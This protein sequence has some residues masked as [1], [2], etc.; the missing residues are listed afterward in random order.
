MSDTE[1]GGSDLP[2]NPEPEDDAD[3]S[4]LGQADIGG[5]SAEAETSAGAFH[6][7]CSQNGVAGDIAGGSDAAQHGMENVQQVQE[8]PSLTDSVSNDSLQCGNI[9]PEDEFQMGSA[10]TERT[11]EQNGHPSCNTGSQGS[12]DIEESPPEDELFGVNT[13]PDHGENFQNGDT[14]PESEGVRESCEMETGASLSHLGS[15]ERMASVDRC[16]ASSAVE[17]EGSHTTDSVE[18]NCDNMGS[19]PTPQGHAVLQETFVGNLFSVGKTEDRED[20]QVPE[21]DREQTLLSASSCE[22]QNSA[23]SKEKHGASAVTLTNSSQQNVCFESAHAVTDR[24]SIAADIVGNAVQARLSP[25]GTEA[26]TATGDNLQRTV[27]DVDNNTFP[28]QIV[29]NTCDSQ[30]AS[31]QPSRPTETSSAQQ[32][33]NQ[34]TAASSTTSRTQKS[35]F[36]EMDS[37]DEDLL[38]KLDAELHLPSSPQQQQQH[39]VMASKFSQLQMPNGLKQMDG[40][41]SELC[42]QFEQQLLQ[43]QEQL[44]Q[45]EREVNRLQDEKARQR[46]VSQDVMAERDKCRAELTALKDKNCDDLY[47]PQIKELEYTIAQQQTEIRQL[48]D[49]LTSHDGAAKRAIATLQSEMKARMDQITKMYEETSREKDS[50]VVRF[51]EAETK[52]IEAKRSVE[53]MEAKVRDVL[54][55]KEF[56]N[57]KMRAAVADRQKAITDLDAKVGEMTAMQKEMEKLKEDLSSADYRI[58]WFQNKLKAELDAHKDTKQNLEK[59]IIKLKETK[60]ETEVIRRDCHAIIKTYQESEE[61]RSNSLDKELKMKQTELLV[62]MKQKSDTDEVHLATKKELD[63][64][65]VKHKDAIEELKTLKDKVHCF[66]EERMTSEQVQNKY[67]TI[68]QNQKGEN[69]NLQKQLSDL[70]TLKEDYDRA[71]DM[72]KNLDHEISDLKITNRD[73]T[74]DIEGCQA[75][76]S[77]MLA[78]QSELSRTNALLRS[79][80][81]NFNNQVVTLS[82]EVQKMSMDLQD[83]E[84]RC[85][86]VTEQ[87]KEEQK[88]REEKTSTLS[89]QLAARTK[90]CDEFKQKWE[91][92]IDSNKTLKRKHAHNV[93]DLT[94][95]LQHAKKRLEVYESGSGER[96]ATSMG[97]RTNSNGSLNSMEAGGQHNASQHSASQHN[98]QPHPAVQ[99]RRQSQEPQDYPVITEQVEV[100][101]QVLIER[102]VRL[103]RSLARKNEKLEFLEE[104]IQ[105]LVAEIK[106]KNKIIQGYIM[107]EEAGT[108][109]SN[110]MDE[111][112]A[113]LARKGGIMASVYSMHQQDGA[114]TLDLSLEINRKLQA[115]LEDTLLKNMTLKENLDTLGAEIARLSQENRRLQLHLQQIA[116]H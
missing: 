92:E 73:L 68:I 70:R 16:L 109:V 22:D 38:M 99:S 110:D 66:E 18:M 53:K 55:E 51:A 10:G 97:S 111:N 105:Q 44:L 1:A 90:E 89:S 33:G 54:K 69:V 107:R 62:H 5:E 113:L 39:L 24:D 35:T 14:A 98:H 103:Q 91:D 50:M 102:I 115:V 81:T 6:M 15:S 85:R 28:S 112:K 46:Q 21:C 23:S 30:T 48:K 96:D 64:L 52:N 94:R 17:F 49:K 4:S 104:H 3:L 93:K 36:L 41:S 20:D 74:K 8:N 77:K 7:E 11:D 42:R 78:L 84:T 71:Q 57:N 19:V 13:S 83:L 101:K 116:T 100:D 9:Q 25:D 63:A 29:D 12:S 95:Q 47:L 60:E 75:R 114:M 2:E 82:G 31:A 65:K 108:L 56:I 40:S 61:V 67:Q 43:L 76:E 37:D 80:N 87:L 86:N 79:E 58:K 45:K 72:I 106:R 27:H 34:E 88:K 32:K 26:D 59:T